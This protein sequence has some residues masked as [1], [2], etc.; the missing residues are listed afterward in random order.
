M[1]RRPAIIKAK[2]SKKGTR[3]PRRGL[4]RF[5]LMPTDTWENAKF[6][7]H[8]EIER[9]DCGNK[10]KDYIKKNFDKKVLVNVNRLPDWKVD[11]L[12]HWAAT[13]HLVEVNPGIVPEIYKIGIVK[14]VNELSAEGSTLST[15]TAE[16]EMKP[17][18]KVNIQ[19]VMREK[20]DEAL[21]EIEAIFDEFINSGYAKNF[22]VNKRVVGALS[23]HNVLPQ[24]LT[25]AIK[26]YNQLLSEYLEVQSGK[27]DQ[28]NEGYSRYS[29]MQ[30]RYMIK[31]IED[32]IAE[33][34]GYVSLKQVTK[35][36]RAKKAVPVEKVVSRL[37][38]CKTF[39]DESLNLELTGLS[40]VKLH[41]CSEAFVYDTA[42]RKIIWLV[43]DDYSKSLSVKGNTV[44]GFDKKKSM[45]KT[46]R[47]PGEFLK[48]MMSASRPATRKMIDEIKAVSAIPNGRFNENIVILK[49]W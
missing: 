40:P 27:C 46:V 13:A 18:R 10:V 14:W 30:I 3:S 44:L 2:S 5:S 39:K 9:K 38:Y 34:N 1:A 29:K 28:L 12:S 20:A 7:A 6:F 33:M 23:S 36:P 25:S 8:Y 35:K 41:Q 48:A 24:H 22:N 31:F 16:D 11:N 49:V 4:N 43:A 21:S 45:S 42:K 15:K 47:K 19:E 17:V 32:V 26:R 37:K